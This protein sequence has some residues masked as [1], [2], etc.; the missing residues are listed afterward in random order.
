MAQNLHS[1]LA[2]EAILFFARF[3]CAIPM[4]VTHDEESTDGNDEG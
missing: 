3:F 1:T 2:G 4:P